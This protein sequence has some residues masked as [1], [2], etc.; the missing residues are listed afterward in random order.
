MYLMQ[1]SSHLQK[2]EGAHNIGLQ[3]RART[4]NRP[5]NMALGCK[6]HDRTRFVLACELLERAQI[7]KICAR[8]QHLTVERPI[9]ADGLKIL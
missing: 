5:I 6:M 8:K 3:E 9:S 4:M 7:A 2:V 1:I